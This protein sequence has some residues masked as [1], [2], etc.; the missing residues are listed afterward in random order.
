[1]ENC[2][3]SLLDLLADDLLASLRSGPGGAPCQVL[4]WLDPEQQFARLVERLEPLVLAPQAQRLR[5]APGRAR[6][7]SA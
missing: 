2:S 1:M 7:S 4:L 5:Y 6:A 3:A